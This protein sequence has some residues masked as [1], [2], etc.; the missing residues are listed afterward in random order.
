MARNFKH[1]KYKNTGL[2]YELLIRQVTSDVLRGRKPV[3]LNIIKKFFKK[4]SALS[5]EL[6]VYDTLLNN[7]VSDTNFALKM[8]EDILESKKNLDKKQLS[9]QKYALVK[10]IINNFDKEEFFKTKIANYKI[11]ASI[12]NLLEYSREENP[13]DF[14][15]NKITIAEHVVKESKQPTQN[16]ATHLKGVDSELKFLTLKILTEKFNNKWGSLS[17]PQKSILRHF[18]FNS[19][20]SKESRVFF[21]EHVNSL[22][23]RIEATKR[24]LK[25]TVLRVK[26]GKIQEYLDSMN[27]TRTSFIHEDHYLTL[28]R[29]YELLNELNKQHV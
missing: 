1:K 24:S 15:K 19:V 4:D 9:S 27:P 14:V 6:Q 3:A 13:S 5:E 28:L 17:Q 29:Y 2:L 8:V 18:I 10:E 22:K 21:V 11:Y 25:D 20:D 7:K 26:L 12:C 16:A 23:S